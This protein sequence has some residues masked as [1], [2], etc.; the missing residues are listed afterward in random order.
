[1]PEDMTPKPQFEANAENIDKIL[2]ALPEELRDDYVCALRDTV[3][4]PPGV[5][6]YGQYL[7]SLAPLVFATRDE[8]VEALEKLN[9]WNMDS[10]NK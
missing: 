2:Q 9:R 8:K 5:G 1:M 7:G 3:K 6:G 10:Y 4:N